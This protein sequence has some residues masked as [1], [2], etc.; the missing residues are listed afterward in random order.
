MRKPP[1]R[2][3]LA[4]FF[5]RTNIIN[6]LTLGGKVSIVYAP[7]Q[8][9]HE[10]NGPEQLGNDDSN[11]PEDALI[12]CSQDEIASEFTKQ[13]GSDFR[14]VGNKWMHWTSTHWQP[15]ETY[16]V[17]DLIRKIARKYAADADGLAAAQKMKIASAATIAGAVSMA[18]SAREHA[19]T[20]EQ[21]D[22]DPMMLNTPG[23][24]V[25]LRTG[26]LKPHEP[27]L[28]MTKITTITPKDMPTPAWDKF[29]QRVQP[30]AD[31]RAYLDRRSGYALTGLTGEQALFFDYGTGANG[32]SVYQTA[33]LEILG[34]YAVTA[35]M[36]LLMESQQD[37]HPTELAR[38]HKAR[39]VGLAETRQGRRWSEERIKVMTGGDKIA[40]R[41]MR[42]D[43]FEFSPEFKLLIMGNHMPALRN[44]DE[45]ISRRLQVVG[46]TVKIPKEERIDFTKFLEMLRPEFPGI[47]YKWIQ[48][49]LEWQQMR[50]SP[51]AAVISTTEEYLDSEDNIGRW[52]NDC[53]TRDFTRVSTN[54]ELFA[55][56]CKWCEA[57][58]EM[59]G[60]KKI[61][62]K[63]LRERRY[64]DAKKGEDKGLRG[65]AING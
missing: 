60:Q 35:P 50:L 13:Y 55:S 33:L 47:L 16:L 59:P 45:A 56:W 41:Y 58:G 34:S 5:M 1:D 46:W 8:R 31:I 26:E 20:L 32:K 27:A 21:F 48:G 9:G 3:A 42:Q 12:A 43:F 51:P 19:A 52:L 30:D 6:D 40:A 17:F 53:T 7:E 63:K 65:I 61:L 25:N 22:R 23:G 2:A 64:E 62:L 38:L 37:R 15:E 39:A 24:V 54:E 44:V 29:L 14:Y 18:R 10:A 57:Q 11:E 49:C 36:E 4:E 28:Y